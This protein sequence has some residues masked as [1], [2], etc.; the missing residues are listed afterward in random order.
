MKRNTPPG[1]TTCRWKLGS[2][3]NINK[4]G[5]ANALHVAGVA[6]IRS[7]AGPQENN[8]TQGISRGFTLIELMVVVAIIGILATVALPS[9]QDYIRRSQLPEAFTV[10][11]DY[12]VK[13]EQYFQDNRAYGFNNTC[14]QGTLSFP[15]AAA[16]YFSYACNTTG[17]HQTYTLSATGVTGAV[18]GHTYTLNSAGIKGTSE[19]KGVDTTKTCWLVTGQEC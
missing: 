12:S 7:H 15:P 9:Y 5:G 10:L 8:P 11:S 4:A 16:K 18:V 1:G 2:L 17:P 6:G 14:G 19:F 3:H 13:L